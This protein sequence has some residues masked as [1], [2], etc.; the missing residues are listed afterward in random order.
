VVWPS[1]RFFRG[2]MA[3]IQLLPLPII[4][5]MKDH[6]VLC[7]SWGLRLDMNSFQAFFF[8]DDKSFLCCVCF[9]TG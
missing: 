7:P 6:A 3:A 8:G 2:G 1:C 4:A 9:F 5:F